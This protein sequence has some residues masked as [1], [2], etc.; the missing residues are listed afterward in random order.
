MDIDTAQLINQLL[1]GVLVGVSYSL[2]AMAFSLIFA[3]SGVVN[4]ATG[5]FAMLGAYFG[6]TFLSKLHAGMLPA[7]LLALAALFVF[8]MLLERIAFRRLYK[9]DPILILIAT[10]GVST[11]LKNVVLLFAGPYSQGYPPLVSGGPIIIGDIIILPQNLI[12]L[13]VGLC[14]MVVFHLFM[15]RTR[16][17]TAMRATA[18]NIRGAS[19]VGI[20]TAFCVNLSWALGAVMAG[21]GGILIA[22]AYNISIEMGASLGIKGFT[23]AVLGGF[24][25]LPASMAG[26]VLLGVAENIGAMLVSYDYKDVFALALIIVILLVKPAGLFVAQGRMRRL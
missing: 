20:D 18:Q 11:M 12:L 6:Y 8:G 1:W 14:A 25:N 26:G 7:V 23:G 4:F 10:I 16:L 5:E 3:T 22:F 19:L 17:G 9:L 15:T 2:L 13:A 24:G 21:I